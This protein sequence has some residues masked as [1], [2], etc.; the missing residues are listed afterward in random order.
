MDAALS[1]KTDDTA[2]ASSVITNSTETGILT[3]F[4]S[5]FIIPEIKEEDFAFH[6]YS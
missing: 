3:K 1:C 4:C 6:C 2:K 5:N